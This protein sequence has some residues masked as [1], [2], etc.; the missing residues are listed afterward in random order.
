MLRASALSWI[1]VLTGEQPV[2]RVSSLKLHLS[3]PQSLAYHC[4]CWSVGLAI[5][6]PPVSSLGECGYGYDR[7]AAI[8]GK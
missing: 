3:R 5:S 8:E 4:A 2:R 6:V 1:L 7:I